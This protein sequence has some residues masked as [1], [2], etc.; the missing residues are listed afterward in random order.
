MHLRVEGRLDD[1]ASPDAEYA[2]KSDNPSTTRLT[3]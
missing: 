1:R 3:S 2:R